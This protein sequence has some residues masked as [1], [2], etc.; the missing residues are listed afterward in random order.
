MMHANEERLRLYLEAASAW[1]AA[2]PDVSRKIA[3][4]PLPEAHAILIERAEGVLPLRPMEAP[5]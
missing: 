2:W 4:M 3:D 1:A 5:R